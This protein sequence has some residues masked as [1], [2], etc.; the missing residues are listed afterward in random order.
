MTF[1]EHEYTCNVLQTLQS[2][3][4]S[5]ERPS[6]F[7]QIHV[8]LLNQRATNFLLSFFLRSVKIHFGYLDETFVEKILFENILCCIYLYNVFVFREN[9][10]VEKWDGDGDVRE[11]V[12]SRSV[13]H[14]TS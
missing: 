9:N 1:L 5:S 12:P 7:I 8:L 6:D 4:G 13:C 2:R 10:N 11:N 14:W 3:I